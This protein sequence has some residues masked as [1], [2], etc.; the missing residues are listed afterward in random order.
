[1]KTKKT[2]PKSRPR[3][4]KT[5]QE[6]IGELTRKNARLQ[7]KVEEFREKG[8]QFEEMIRF[9]KVL[10]EISTRLVHLPADQI[11]REIELGLRRVVKFLGVDRGSV[12]IFSG[13]RTRIFRKY[14]WGMEGIPESAPVLEDQKFPWLSRKL[15]KGEM[16]V[17][18][19]VDDLPQEAARDREEL[20]KFRNLSSLVIPLAVGKNVFGAVTFGAVRIERNWPEGLIQR[21]RLVGEIF[22]SALSRKQSEEALRQAE[23]EYRMV[24]EFTYD[25][26]YW[27]NPDGTIRYMS[28]SCRRITGY[29][30]DEFVN[31][32]SL[33]REIILPIDRGAWDQ[34]FRES[35]RG[36]PSHEIQFRIRKP[37]G[38]VRWIEHACQSVR[39]PQGEFLGYRVS[40]R[41][42]T[43]RRMAEEAARKKDESLAEAQRI[44]HMGNWHWN[45]ETN[46]L[47]WS[48]EVYRIFG[49][50]PQEFGATYDAFLEFVHPGDR[51]AVKDA[52]TRSLADP[53]I[54]YGIEHRVV[55]PDHSERIVHERG[56]VTF[57]DGG[58][59][60]RMIGTVQDITERKRAEELI[61]RSQEELRRL[62]VQL[63]SVQEE[64][65]KRIARELHDGIGQSLSAMKFLLENR[66][67]WMEKNSPPGN[68]RDLE[69]MVPMI[70]NAIEEVRRIQSD[71]RPPILDDLGILATISWFCREYQGIYGSIRVQRRLEVEEDEVP[72]PL[73]TVIYRVLQEAMNNVAKHS[74]ATK[75]L[76]SLRKV[77]DCLELV[78]QDNGVGVELD[79]IISRKSEKYGFGLSSMRER[80][81]LS[82]GFFSVQSGKGKGTTIQASWK[83]AGEA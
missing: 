79:R 2:S 63:L 72:P 40:N 42:V 68:L 19:R 17:I 82:G 13:D 69:S 65:R 47:A 8:R 20:K 5:P 6:K 73:K 12:Y 74:Q 57:D 59:P 7:R 78:I 54:L 21:I 3:T 39:S 46:E 44:A 41:D 61:Q 9:E 38:Q 71:L 43:E 31:H 56:E 16:L 30:P 53:S 22:A 58:R 29:S 70:Q 76:L 27:S 45:I 77:D 28:P 37:D 32:P 33:I 66:L 10:S 24:A 60:I 1:V 49:L 26:E 67:H 81:E 34:H 15:Q 4:G 50:L 62:S 64:E 35:R 11:E 83:V 52:V 14:F 36:V 55:R 51:E 48:D 23:L 80:T 25:W 75:I 18:P